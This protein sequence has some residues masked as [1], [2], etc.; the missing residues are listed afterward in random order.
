[1]K[2][3][4]KHHRTAKYTLPD[5]RKGDDEKLLK[6]LLDHRIF[7][8]IITME[9]L[10]IGKESF[11]DAKRHGLWMAHVT[12]CDIEKIVTY[13]HSG[14]Y[15]TIPVYRE[16]FDGL[17]DN[18]KDYVTEV[19][20]KHKVLLPEFILMLAKN[21]NNDVVSVCYFTSDYFVTDNCSVSKHS[22]TSG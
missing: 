18:E 11:H 13:D 9:T 10:N 22:A 15:D 8:D 14:W 19:L 16:Y 7:K 3:K 5:A 21:D 4:K 17:P 2:N 6:V 1:M 12:W 20:D